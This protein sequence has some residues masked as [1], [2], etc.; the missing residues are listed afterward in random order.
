M[1]DSISGYTLYI[2]KDSVRSLMDSEIEQSVRP[3]SDEDDFCEFVIAD[4]PM[5]D[6]GKTREAFVQYLIHWDGADGSIKKKTL[7]R[8]TLLN[9]NNSL[10]G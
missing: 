2:W 4:Y 3:D 8:I 7:L 9:L 10:F 6:M 1:I 5:F